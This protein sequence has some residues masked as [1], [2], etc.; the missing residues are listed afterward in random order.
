MVE[1]TD[2]EG[3]RLD[4]FLLRTLKGVPKSRIYR[5][6]RKGEVRINK[7]RCKPEDKLQRGDLVR[8]PP[9]RTASR[10]ASPV[11]GVDLANLLRQSVIAETDDFLVFNKPAGMS[12]HGGSGV[13]IGLIEALRQLEPR[14]AR[15]ELAH[16]LDRDTSG[17][18]VIAKQTPFLKYLH[19]ALKA[20]KVHKHYLALVS[21]SWPARLTEIDAPLSKNQLLSGERVVKSD[22]A[23]KPALTRFKVLERFGDTATLVEAMPVTGRTH[24]IRVHCLIG[25]HPIVS[26]PKYGAK[27]RG[28]GQRLAPRL[29][30]HAS[31]IQFAW[32]ETAPGSSYRAALPEDL[33]GA[34][35][36]LR[37]KTKK[38]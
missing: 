35:N 12:I 7:G 8:I 32:P 19:D 1:I 14:W 3:Q 16:R 22:A 18:V 30:L 25:G 26:D 29:F 9:V 31:E 37:N 27:S 5:L 13:R 33:Q 38:A 34:L 4:N 21:G 6:I 2:A 11:P 36:S 23:G 15:L 28:G 10:S 20:R 17:C 24:Q